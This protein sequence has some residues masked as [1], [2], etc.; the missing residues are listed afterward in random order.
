M[1]FTIKDKTLFIS[2]TEHSGLRYQNITKTKKKVPSCFSRMPQNKEINTMQRYSNYFFS[3][4]IIS[5]RN[6]FLTF[7]KILTIPFKRN[8]LY[9]RINFVIVVFLNKWNTQVKCYTV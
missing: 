1:S 5:K 6:D 9:Y 4:N 7:F 2:H 8:F 3:P